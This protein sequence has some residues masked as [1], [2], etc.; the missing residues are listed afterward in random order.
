MVTLTERKVSLLC[1]WTFG[2]N[3]ISSSTAAAAHGFGGDQ[4]MV[5]SSDSFSLHL[6]Q[7]QEQQMISL[8]IQ[9]SINTTTTRPPIF[10]YIAK[11]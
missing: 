11:S 6:L 10:L 2:S 9:N 1:E 5:L 7:K 8:I 3:T 4:P